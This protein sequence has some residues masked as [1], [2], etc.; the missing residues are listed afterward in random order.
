MIKIGTKKYYIAD[1]SERNAAIK[2]INKLLT[3]NIV[4][5]EEEEVETPPSKSP[6]PSPEDNLDD[7]A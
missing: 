3:G 1:L 6:S 4:K 5:P 7:D 2:H